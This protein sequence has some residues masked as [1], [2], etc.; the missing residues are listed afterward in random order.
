MTRTITLKAVIYFIFSIFFTKVTIAT[1]TPVSRLTTKISLTQGQLQGT[2]S[3][4]NVLAYKG[5]PYA[6]APVGNLRWRAP[7]PAPK[8]D[9]VR[10][11]DKFG[12]RP[13][14]D[15]NL[16]YEFRSEEVSED[17]LFLNV[18]TSASS[19]QERKP[20]YIY[21]HGG[22]FIHGDGSQVAYDGTSMAKQGIVYVSINYRLGVFGFMSHPELSK[23]S[24]Y[25]GSG[26]YGLMDQ[27]AAIKWVRENIAAFGGDPNRITIGG[28]SVGAQSVS[29]LMATPLSKGLFSGAIA[30]SGSLLDSKALVIPLKKSEAMG[31]E[32]SLQA[33]S[34][35]IADLR[36]MSPI[37]LLKLVEKGNPRRFKPTIDGYFL[38]ER[39]EETFRKG[40]QA[41]IPLLMG[42]N[43]QEVPALALYRLRKMNDKN[44]K[45]ALR[46]FYGDHAD[47]VL[48]LYPSGNKA[49]LKK[50][51]GEMMSDRLINY[52]SFKL[53][54]LHSS[55]PKVSVYRYLFAHPHPG[56]NPRTIREGS[57][58]QVLIKKLINGA[59]SGTSF[60]ASEIEYALGNLDVQD[61]Y[62]WQ[63]ADYRVSEQ[64]QG[65]FVN[66]IKNGNPNSSVTEAANEVEWPRY[67]AEEGRK[68]IKI[69]EASI[70]ETEQ[71][72]KRYELLERLGKEE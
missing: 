37:K 14:Q 72:T 17:C 45:T 42:W 26:N 31:T 9:G 19:N 59:I 41:K 58:L 2:R 5:I 13:I 61:N 11:A 32:I 47:E 65:Y 12:A 44:Y 36:A 48:A 30:E 7:Q 22:S 57:F 60:H 10:S 15:S 55:N 46:K 63:K 25:G 68:F 50:S 69:Q 70:I 20:V 16:L 34:P 8:W 38:V 71:Q 67:R 64:M 1:E 53:A 4:H 66:F 35:S 62:A 40:N 21:I 24:T 49:E 3:E 56:L 39:P 29:A 52:S 28:E 33:K 6:A 43:A 54:E 23:E 27:L 51:S 18:W